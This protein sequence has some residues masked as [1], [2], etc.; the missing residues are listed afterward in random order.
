MSES[1][2]G[3]LGSYDNEA[4]VPTS[5]LPS[6]ANSQTPPRDQSPAPAI[7]SEEGGGALIPQPDPQPMPP[8]VDLCSEIQEEV[9]QHSEDDVE[10]QR[11]VQLAMR[12]LPPESTENPS[13]TL[14]EKLN[15]FHRLR[16]EKQRSI[17][18]DL[19]KRKNFANPNILEKLVTYSGLEES[20]SNIPA[21]LFTLQNFTERDTYIGIAEQQAQRDTQRANEQR[22]RTHIPFTSGG[23][24]RPR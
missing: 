15:K 3:L 8:Q 16:E 23:G 11:L 6:A 24:Y 1:L 19:F 14:V 10:A 20:G 21:S 18:S 9:D 4:E 7:Q 13:P 2:M 5:L 17:N 22:G 12:F